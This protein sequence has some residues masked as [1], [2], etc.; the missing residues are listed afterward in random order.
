VQEGEQGTPSRLGQSIDHGL[1]A[2]AV[3]KGQ[4][5]QAVQD[6]EVLSA[7]T[8]ELEQSA[9]DLEEDGEHCVVPG[10]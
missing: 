5:H 9:P 6:G 8:H 7:I 10:L 2:L 1:V 3:L 4:R